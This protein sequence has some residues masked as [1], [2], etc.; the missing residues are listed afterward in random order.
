MFIYIQPVACNPGGHFLKVK[1]ALRRTL[2]EG[3]VWGTHTP[4][5]GHLF[6]GGSVRGGHSFLGRRVRRT[7]LPRNNCPAGQLLGG[8][9]IPITP[10]IVSALNLIIWR[11]LMYLYTSGVGTY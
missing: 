1:E 11:R 7:M 2:I 10:D 8:T 4:G 6:L 5:G 9:R 3:Q